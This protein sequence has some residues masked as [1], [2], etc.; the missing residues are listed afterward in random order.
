MSRFLARL[1]P[2]RVV[3]DV[4]TVQQMMDEAGC[5][6]VAR[7]GIVLGSAQGPRTSRSGRFPEASRKAALRTIRS[8]RRPAS[9]G[10]QEAKP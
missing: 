1:F 2:A 10:P 4:R 6:A 5:R 9:A 8:A 7:R 3:R